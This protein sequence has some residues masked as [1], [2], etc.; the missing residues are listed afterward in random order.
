MLCLWITASITEAHMTYMHTPP[1]SGEVL[2]EYLGEISVTEAVLNLG[3]N[4]V[5]PEARCR[6][7]GMRRGRWCGAVQTARCDGQMDCGAS[8]CPELVEGLAMTR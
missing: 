2:R 8:A 4:R 5:T 6:W 7:L 3:V 1:H